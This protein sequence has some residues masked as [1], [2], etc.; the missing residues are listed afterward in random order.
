[1]ENR[2]DYR[3][4]CHTGS[5]VRMNRP[6]ELLLMEL[7]ARSGLEDVEHFAQVFAAA[8]RSGG[9]WWG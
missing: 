9:D 6:V 7:G 5:G 2:D 8:R 4:I 3:R 1:M